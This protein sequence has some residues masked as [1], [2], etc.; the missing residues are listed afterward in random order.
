[1]KALAI[2]VAGFALAA[3]PFIAVGH[4]N[5][6]IYAT[7][8]LSSAAAII[9]GAATSACVGDSIQ[10]DNNGAQACSLMTDALPDVSRYFAHDAAPISAG[11]NQVGARLRFAAGNGVRRAAMTAASFVNNTTTCSV[12]IDGTTTTGTEGTAF[13][14]S[15]VTDTVCATNIAAW[16]DALTGIDSCAG[17]GCTLF[18]GV[19]G[20]AYIWRA[21]DEP[22]AGSLGVF[23]CAAGATPTTGTDGTIDMAHDTV[24]RATKRLYLDGSAAGAGG[25]TYIYESSADQVRHVVG[26]INGIVMTTTAFALAS[27]VTSVTMPGI[28]QDVGATCSTGQVAYDTGGAADEICICHTTNTWGCVTVTTTSGPTD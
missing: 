7:T 27:G 11:A 8:G 1:M 21:S 20:T 9:D 14:C 17:A 25:D 13:E 10:Y 5:P 26:G 2:T 24:L 19:A 3:I 12:I 6:R 18:T 23:T 28:V 16:A 22:G 4:D 15:S